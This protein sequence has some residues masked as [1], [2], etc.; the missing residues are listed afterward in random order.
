M[1]AYKSTEKKETG[2]MDNEYYVYDQIM[3]GNFKTCGKFFEKNSPGKI[4]L[5]NEK[6]V[7][8]IIK[9]AIE[10]YLKW[11]SDYAYEYFD[12]KIAEAMKLDVMIRKYVTFPIEIDSKH[13]YKYIISCLYPVQFPYDTKTYVIDYYKKILSGKIKGFKKG[14]F[15]GDLGNL[16]ARICLGYVLDQLCPE[17]FPCIADMYDLFMGSRGNKLL[18]Q[19]K[20]FSAG[21][22]LFEFP[23]DYFHYSLPADKREMDIYLHLRS[24]LEKK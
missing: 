10:S 11:S 19:Y 2:K 7:L 16:R 12:S 17:Q 22:D 5:I 4:S 1:Q 20:L 9:Y 18:R 13:Y 6:R 23:L 3:L 8:K 21:R 24:I 15:S 14:F